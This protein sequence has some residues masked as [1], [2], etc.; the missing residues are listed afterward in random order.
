M[1]LQ[2]P[3]SLSLSPML[4][5]GKS[6]A[7]F[8]Q[9]TQQEL[10]LLCFLTAFHHLCQPAH[11]SSLVWK[12]ETTQVFTYVNWDLFYL[13][14]SCKSGPQKWIKV[15]RAFLLSF[16]GG[17]TVIMFTSTVIVWLSFQTKVECVCIKS[18]YCILN[19]IWQKKKLSTIKSD[20]LLYFLYTITL[21]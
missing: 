7:V 18:E 5:Y 2:F 19:F 3:P 13:F 21:I 16:W 12:M 10:S 17:S 15:T 20:T 9:Q 1:S 4:K 14:F 6:S 8:P 11:T